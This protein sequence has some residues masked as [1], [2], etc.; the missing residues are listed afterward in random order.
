MGSSPGE[1]LLRRE[2]AVQ[3]RLEE[4]RV[5][6]LATS[7]AQGRPHIVPVCFVYDGRNF[8]TPLDLKPKRVEPAKLARVRH[9]QAN[10][11][12]ALLIDEY[13][14]DWER[15]W[16]I[17]IRGTAAILQEGTE[18]DRAHLLLTG[19]YPQYAA[20]LLPKEAAVIRILPK[21]IICWGKL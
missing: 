18:H 11:N 7:D 10:P 17:L 13:R 15:L 8:Y 14:E 9:I 5:A 21:R 2:T 4:A 19:K 16:Y 1:D 6:R 20:G 12:V 3:R